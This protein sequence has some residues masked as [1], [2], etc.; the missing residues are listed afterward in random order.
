MDV[1]SPLNSSMFSPSSSGTAI[2]E[3]SH[4]ACITFFGIITNIRGDFSIRTGFLPD[5]H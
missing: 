2:F 1:S 3:I 5:T 4:V